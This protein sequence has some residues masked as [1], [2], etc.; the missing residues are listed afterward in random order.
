MVH[1]VRTRTNLMTQS[2][3]P[4][5]CTTTYSRDFEILVVLNL[6]FETHAVS[7]IVMHT[8]DFLLLLR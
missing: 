1:Q 6:K 7:N 8:N 4:V 5:F 2:N 3:S